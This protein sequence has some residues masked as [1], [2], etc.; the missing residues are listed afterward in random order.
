MTNQNFQNSN[1][2]KIH[3]FFKQPIWFPIKKI[4]KLFLQT[5]LIY[6]ESKWEWMSRVGMSRVGSLII[7][8]KVDIC[9]KYFVLNVQK[10]PVILTRN[11]IM[12]TLVFW[13]KDKSC[14]V[15]SSNNIVD[16]SGCVARVKWMGKIYNARL[17][18]KSGNLSSYEKNVPS[19]HSHLQKIIDDEDWLKTL[20]VDTDGIITDKFSNNEP[21]SV[22]TCS[23]L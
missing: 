7:Y 12:F 6:S 2:F 14:S 5:F 16:S 11:K 20:I 4:I 3:S 8:E 10:L 17:L 19:L 18:A 1:N 23:F 13:N 21:M 22:G 15:E 9:C